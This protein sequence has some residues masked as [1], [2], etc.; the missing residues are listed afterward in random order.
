MEGDSKIAETWKR[1]FISISPCVHESACLQHIGENRCI[2]Q[3]VTIEE[4]VFT[5]CKLSSHKSPGM[6]GIP[7]EVFKVATPSLQN[8]LCSCFQKSLFIDFRLKIY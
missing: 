5:A 3:P 6:D 4:V 7:A 8:H 1:D 2:F